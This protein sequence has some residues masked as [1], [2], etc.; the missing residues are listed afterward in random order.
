MAKLFILNTDP[1]QA[2][3]RDNNFLVLVS[4]IIS[5]FISWVAMPSI[6]AVARKKSLVDLPN[7]RT[8]HEGAIPNL[9]GIALFASLIITVL[10]FTNLQ[11]F[12]SVQYITP[13]LVILFFIG[14]KDD[15][16]VI[17]AHSKLL[18][19]IISALVVVMLGNIRFTSLHGFLGIQGISYL[20]SVLLTVFV[21]IVIIN[22]FNLIDGID[23]LAAGMGILTALILSIYFL[24]T[25]QNEYILVSAT[26]VGSLSAFLYYNVFSKK[27]KIFLG[28]T[29]A[30]I[31]GYMMAILVIRF[32]EYNA[33]VMQPYA[34]HAAPAV[35]IALLFLPLYDVLRVFI[36]RIINGQSPFHADRRHLHHLLISSGLSHRKATALLLTMQLVFVGIGFAFQH[37]AIWQ[38]TL[39]LLVVGLTFSLCVKAI[40]KNHTTKKKEKYRK[41]P[42]V[43]AMCQD[44]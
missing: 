43:A 33:M 28:D 7:G 18:G 14:L 16:L 41:T 24:I 11:N 22:C 25:G 6:L 38:L 40:H 2:L 21:I 44:E 12:P 35:S 30:M 3:F 26:L 37:L 9:G 20:S 10:T 29:G 32:N 15:V 13:G 39:L 27:N 17:S 34:I 1:L 23:G 42:W 36:L 19:Q 5:F 8:S 4:L 31:L